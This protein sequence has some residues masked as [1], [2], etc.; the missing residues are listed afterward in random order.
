MQIK[1]DVTALD[2]EDD[3]AEEART[4]YPDVRYRVGDVLGVSAT[5]TTS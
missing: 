2:L 3:H 4:L 5:A 1:L